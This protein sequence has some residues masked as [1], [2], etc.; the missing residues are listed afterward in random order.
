ML[1]NCDKDNIISWLSD[2][3]RGASSEAIYDFLRGAKNFSSYPSDAGDFGRCEGLFECCPD[4][5][6]IFVEHM[7]KA[8]AY[9]AALVP[10]WEEIAESKDATAMIKQIIDPIENKDSKFVRVSPGMSIRF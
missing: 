5:Y 9:W 7:P 1:A 4:I 2:G 10:R 3:R 6:P 8:N